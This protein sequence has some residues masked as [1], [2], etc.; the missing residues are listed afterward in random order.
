MTHEPSA[1]ARLV[2]NPGI[3]AAAVVYDFIPYEMPQRYLADSLSRIRYM[4]NLKWLS[5]YQLFFAISHATGT[6]LREL[7][8]TAVE[9]IGVTGCALSPIFEP[10][11]EGIETRHILVVGGGDQRKNV[12]CAV[13]AHA[14]CSTTQSRGIPLLLLGYRISGVPYRC[15]Q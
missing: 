3:L 15:K 6:K 9:R 13:R 4:T 5:H 2:G 12:D 14:H 1:V 10:P 11:P 8:G 7:L